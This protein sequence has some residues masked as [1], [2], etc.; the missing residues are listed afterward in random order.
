MSTIKSRK[1]FTSIVFPFVALLVEFGINMFITPL[2]TDRIGTDAYGFVALAKNFTSYAL[3]MTT[4]LN[5]YAARF[6]S[7]EY[8]KKN[9]DKANEYFSSTFFA[10]V[11][12]A[13][14]I[15]I[16]GVVIILFLE[17]IINIPSN[18][19][20][21]V[22]LLFMF[23]FLNFYTSSINASYA[24]SS[25][26]ANK[27]DLNG[28]LKAVAYTVEAIFLVAIYHY[29]YPRVFYMGMGILIATVIVLVS[30][31]YITRKFVPEVHLERKSFSCNA[32]K[33]LVF[34]GIWNSIN[35]LG[36]TLNSGLDLIISNLMLNAFQMGQLAISH[37]INTML[38]CLYQLLSRPFYPVFLKDYAKGDYESL[39]SD[40]FFAM[41]ASGLVTALAISG[42]VGLG[43]TFFEIWIPNQD[44]NFI[45]RITIIVLS[46][47]VAQG[48]VYPLYY[49]YTLTIKNKVPCII[50]IIGGSINVFSMYMLLRF[51][52]LGLYA[53]VLTTLVIMTF[54]NL[55][56]N[57]I[58]MTH[59]LNMPKGVFYPTIIRHIIAFFIM[60][61]FFNV[62]TSI[63]HPHGLIM[64]IICGIAY[65]IIG[66]ILYIIVV[67]SRNERVKIRSMLGRKLGQQ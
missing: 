25:L 50:T 57:P 65:S 43:E 20:A 9:Y 38:S 35:A 59:C 66:V 6:I 12:L 42:F 14:A 41:K 16:I 67:F 29:C 32:V 51:T 58:Y 4:A 53:V 28:A 1:L 39:K 21:D 30:D 2:I 33:E 62:L 36:N 31:V 8:H 10:D 40:L 64:L 18:I 61:M 34:N 49:I 56:T 15:L 63:I 46:V 47:G 17:F 44:I 5:S 26:I 24:A 55:V 11:Y 54:I 48:V 23:I 22:K 3:I 27:V 37:V 13:G 19:V 52:Q 7:V 60:S 45:Y